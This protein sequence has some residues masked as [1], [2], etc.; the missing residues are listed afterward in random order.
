MTPVAPLSDVARLTRRRTEEI[1]QTLQQRLFV[2]TDRMFAVLM[3]A[4]WLFG[5]ALA[6]WLSPRAWEGAESSVHLHVWAAA[7]LGGVI[8]GLPIALAILYPGRLATRMAIAIGQTLTSALLIHVTGGRIETHFHVF[9]SLAF[10]A[11]YRDWRVL[12]PATIV[13]AVDHFVRGLFWPQSVYGV[14]TAST[15]R[16]L[17]HAGWVVFEDVV[18]VFSCIRGTRELWDIAERTAEHESSEERYR[19]VV[20]H[21]AD[22]IVVFDAEDHTILECNPAFLTMSGVTREEAGCARIDTIVSPLDGEP[23]VDY[24]RLIVEGTEVERTLWRADG[25]ARAVAC[26]VSPTMYARKRAMCVV[27][28]DITERKRVETALARA[29]DEAVQSARL[30]SEFLANMSHEIRTPM[31]GVLGMSGLLLETELSPHQREFAQTIQASAEGLLGI[32]ND[33]LDFSKV[34]AGKLHFEEVDFDLQQAVD[35]TTDL[36]AKSAFAKGIELAAFVKP[37]VPGALRG[38]PGRLRQVLTN[39]LGNG[40]KFT[41]RGEVV[42]RVTVEAQPSPGRALLRFEVKDTGIGIAEANQKRLFEAFTQADG[43]TTR[44]YGGTGLGLAISKR[45]VELMGGQIGVTSQPGAGSTFWFTAQL[46][47]QEAR[48]VEAPP[49]ADLEGRYV[50]VVDDNQT[51]R[52]ILRHQLTAWAVRTHSVSS[53][54]AALVALEEAAATGS[55][56]DLAIID[57][58]MP[59]MD[60]MALA[61]AIRLRPDIGKTPLIMMTSIGTPAPADE[62]AAA[63]IVMCLTKPVKQTRIRECLAHVLATGAAAAPA[64][65][66]V[67][68]A[69][70]RKTRQGRVLVAED[71]G[72]NQRVAQLH[73]GK[74]GYVV[75]L[76]G[77]GAEAVDAVMRNNYDVV[78]MDC[79]MPEMDGYEATRTIRDHGSDIPIIAMT[80]NAL[81]GDRE[82]CLEA[83]MDDYISKPV[84]MQQLRAVLARFGTVQSTPEPETVAA[85]S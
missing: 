29:R 15:W 83:G 42:L 37:E 67:A 39:L 1:F 53:G 85:D 31:N 17:E 19:A 75:D 72:V 80:A 7:L 9:G 26:S 65:A 64:T 2:G 56:F 18:L 46:A 30:K 70:A 16:F 33:I 21:T 59:E 55:P 50:L 8:S 11:F 41:E 60:G 57:H 36:L 63:G 82:R 14:L 38:D 69:A 4:Q 25:T 81:S 40:I 84:D 54:A 74:L 61:H 78:L 71:N 43:S 13:V 6:L 5:I 49:P 23:L 34:E 48:A 51:N 10:L 3:T 52:I 20:G 62:L 73:L 44:K 24:E 27:I 35:M 22:A 32:I 79:Q 47:I 58:Q 68:S 12:V 76:V 28:R 66:V 77:N 45:L